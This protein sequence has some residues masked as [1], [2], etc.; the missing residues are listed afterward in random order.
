MTRGS[1]KTNQA[2]H[3]LRHRRTMCEGVA[4]CIARNASS[5]AAIAGGKKIGVELKRAPETAKTSQVLGCLYDHINN[6]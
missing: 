5:I 4:L 1:G 3:E 6:N 2:L